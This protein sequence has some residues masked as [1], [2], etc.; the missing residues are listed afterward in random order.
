MVDKFLLY[1]DTLGFSKMVRNDVNRVRRLY[2]IVENL[3]VQHH[4][5]FKII[6]FSDTF[7]IYNKEDPTTDDERRYVVW[8]TIEFFQNLFY[9]CAGKD[10]YFRAVL[11][12]GEFEHITTPKVDRFYGE[13]LVDAYE[14]QRTINCTGLFIDQYCQKY[15]EYF[16]VEQY[17]DKLSYVFVN[18]SLEHFC[19][20][21]LA[22]WPVDPKLMENGD[23]WHLAKDIHFL[24]DVNRLMRCHVEPRVR[25]KYLATWDYY[26]RR[27]GRLM[28][29]LESNGFDLSVLSKEFDWGPAIA[30]IW[31]E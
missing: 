30:G 21:E 15:N 13:A 10:Y 16:P 22:D 6:V 31:D 27:Y 9:E 8:Y 24:K 17:D 26:Y 19:R 1:I 4:R 11:V 18:Q 25:G 14:H 28:Y 3:T 2:D 29:D 7:L 20:G 23:P 5:D 12:H